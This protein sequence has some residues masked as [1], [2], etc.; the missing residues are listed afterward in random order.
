MRLS[1]EATTRLRT[2]CSD[3]GI[4]LAGFTEAVGLRIGRGRELKVAELVALAR[5]V[6]AER[7]R[8]Q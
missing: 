5:E 8:R 3:N 6:D 2:F 7:R 1:P 4:T